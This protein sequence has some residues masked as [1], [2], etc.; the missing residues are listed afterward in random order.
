[1]PD[2]GIEAGGTRPP[3]WCGNGNAFNEARATPLANRLAARA[4]ATT[5]G[6]TWWR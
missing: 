1:M 5:P 3:G 2:T 6:T 4:P